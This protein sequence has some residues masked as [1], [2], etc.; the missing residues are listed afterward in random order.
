MLMWLSLRIAP[1]ARF[2]YSY[3]S[4][5]PAAEDSTAADTTAPAETESIDTADTDTVG[6]I[7]ESTEKTGCKAMAAA[8]VALTT[9]AA[10]AI[11]IKK[12]KD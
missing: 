3:V 7:H 8:A 6:S 12:K 5:T 9:A 11:M 1:G 4:G 2:K 10:A